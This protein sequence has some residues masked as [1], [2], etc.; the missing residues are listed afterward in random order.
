MADF[1]YSLTQFQRNPFLGD[2]SAAIS[3]AAR[4]GRRLFTDESTRCAQCHNGPS[5]QNQLF[6]DKVPNGGFELGVPPGAA[7]NNPFKRQAVGTANIFD[8]TDPAV[9]SA[10]NDT[11]QNSNGRELGRGIPATRGALLDYVTPVLNDVWDTAPFLHDGSAPTLLD[12]V[13]PCNALRGDDCN[14]PGTG[15]NVDDRHGRTSHLTPQQLNDLVAFQRAPHNPVGE[16]EAVVRA[17]GLAVTKARLKLG[18][19]PERGS[20]AVVA[21]VE[22]AALPVDAANQG[23]ALT[24][25]VPAGETMAIHDIVATPV[26]LRGKGNGV[27]FRSRAAGKVA[28]SLKRR[29]N[30]TLRLVAKGRR[31]D[32]RALD[33]GSRDVTVALVIGDAQFVQNRLLRAKGEGGRTLVLR[34]GRRA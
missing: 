5:A 26:E 2:G 11:F 23:L 33:T 25:G 18:K 31:V 8:L 17:G 28:I 13:R 29:G 4:R 24:L 16:S 20:F 30:G 12:V 22:P 21:T 10:E 3:E 7:S 15:R 14:Q 6:T 34:K 19:R 27:R 32:L 1:V 9:V